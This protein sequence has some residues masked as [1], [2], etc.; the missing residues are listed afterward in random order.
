MNV[1]D[2]YLRSV[3]RRLRAI[4]PEHRRAVLDDLRGHFADAGDA[5]RPVDET[6][7]GL[8][9]AQ[10]IADRAVE[11][12]GADASASYGRAER[13]WRVLQ[14]TAVAT[15]IV[16]GVVAA[17]I[18]PTQEMVMTGTDPDG[19]VTMTPTT[20]IAEAMGLGAALFALI[21][22]VLTAVPLAVSRN[23]RAVASVLCT[24]ALTCV[25]FV[26]WLVP[27]DIFMPAVMLAWSALIVRW[28]MPRGGFGWGW[29]VLGA[30]LAVLPVAA[31]LLVYGATL[32]FGAMPRRYADHSDLEGGG[33]SLGVEGGGW[34]L[35]AAVVS[36]AV[37]MI[38]GRRWVG[39]VL[40]AV[41]AA[42]LVTALISGSMLISLITWVGGWW[43]TIGLAHA[44]ATPRRR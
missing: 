25:V 44:V 29:R 33:P 16:L 22:A 30:A 34:V 17:F 5:G 26:S 43:L 12:F 4:A 18:M 40:A 21:P 24:S 10:E 37:I 3:E 42:T 2:S 8:G 31:F 11:E 6:I 15:A 1:E 41:G 7:R 28:R 39:W 27:G 36:I 35:A 38:I 9:S 20:T 23:G 32:P 13:A 14:G 19:M